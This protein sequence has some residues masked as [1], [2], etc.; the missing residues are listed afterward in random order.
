MWLLWFARCQFSILPPGLTNAHLT[1]RNLLSQKIVSL[2]HKVTVEFFCQVDIVT[3]SD[4]STPM[5]SK[6]QMSS[7]RVY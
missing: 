5:E 4:Q 1:N 7:S 6:I 2:S 3:I